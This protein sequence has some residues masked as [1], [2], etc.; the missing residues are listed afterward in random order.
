MLFSCFFIAYSYE[1]FLRERK[2][3]MGIWKTFGASRRQ[4]F[5]VIFLEN[6]VVGTFSILVG[7]LLGMLLSKVFFNF[8]SDILFFES[9]VHL[10]FF[11]PWLF[12]VTVILFGIVFLLVFVSKLLKD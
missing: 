9:I 2:K 1:H 11:L 8:M 6:A 10:Y 12:F 7:I 5:N 3:E 4:L